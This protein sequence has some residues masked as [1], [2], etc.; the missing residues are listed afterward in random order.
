LITEKC[1]SPE[2]QDILSV[3]VMRISS[4]DGSENALARDNMSQSK[5]EETHLKS[6]Q[7][8]FHNI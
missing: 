8:A 7:G 4:S 5:K 3:V 6:L 2:E 1:F